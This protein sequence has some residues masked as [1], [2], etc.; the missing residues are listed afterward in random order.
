MPPALR[1]PLSTLS[2]LYELVGGMA[3]FFLRNINAGNGGIFPM[4]NS[5]FESLSLA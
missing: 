1:M 2:M 5:L 3:E 4:E